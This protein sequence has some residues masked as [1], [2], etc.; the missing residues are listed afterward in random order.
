MQPD[1]FMRNGVCFH[2]T[3]KIYVIPGL[4]IVRVQRLSKAKGNSWLIC[5]KGHVVGIK[6]FL[7]S[8]SQRTLISQVSSKLSFIRPP[9]KTLH[10]R[11]LP[12]SSMAGV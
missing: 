3:F 2:I 10:A 4:Q 6:L 5:K 8:Y 12:S 11:Y 1:Q 9:A 7:F